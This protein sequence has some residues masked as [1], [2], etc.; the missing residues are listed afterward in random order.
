MSSNGHEV[1]SIYQATPLQN[2]FYFDELY[3]RA[4]K[5]HNQQTIEIKGSFDLP[6]FEQSLA[7]IGRRHETLRANFRYLADGGLMQIIERE[8][9]PEVRC[10]NSDEARVPEL[11]EEEYRREFKLAEGCLWRTLVVNLGSTRHVIVITCHHIIIDGWSLAMVMGELLDVYRHLSQGKTPVLKQPWPL[12]NYFRWLRQRSSETAKTFWRKY[13]AG[14]QPPAISFCRPNPSPGQY[15]PGEQLITLDPKTISRLRALASANHFTDSTFFQVAWAAVLQCYTSSNDTV[16]GVVVSGRSPDCAGIEDAVG[17]FINTVPARIQVDANSKILATLIQR[18]ADALEVEETGILTLAEVQTYAEQKGALIDHLVVFENFPASLRQ[19]EFSTSEVQLRLVRVREQTSYDFN[20]IITP[21]EEL[22]VAFK[23]NRQTMPDGYVTRLAGHYERVVKTMLD[24]PRD[25]FGDLDLLSPEERRELLERFND[26]VRSQPERCVHEMVEEQAAA[27]PDAVAIVLENRELSYADLNARA[28]QLAHR[29][30][31]LGVGPEEPVAILADRSFE[32]VVAILATLKAGGAYVPIAPNNPA[33]R[34]EQILRLSGCRMLL[35]FGENDTSKLP[36]NETVLELS[37]PTWESA[38]RCNPPPRAQLQNLAYVIFTS[39]STGQP[40]GCMVTHQALASHL[41]WM[42]KNYRL[43]PDDVV[44]QKTTYTFDV[45]IWELLLPLIVGGKTA[46]LRPGAEKDPSAILQALEEHQTTV[47][48]FVPSMLGAFLDELPPEKSLPAW[49]QCWC[50][51]EPLTRAH[52]SLFH[53]KTGGA[54]E[55]HNLYGPTEATIIVASHRVSPEEAVIPIGRTFANTTLYVL[56]NWSRPVPPGVIGELYIGGTQVA[57]GYS[58]RPDLTADRFGADPFS[59]GGRLYRTGD[60][61]RWS[62]QGS[63]ELLGRTDDQ[64]KIRGYRIELAEIAG[65]LETHPAVKTA[66]VVARGDGDLRHL[67][68][69]FVPRGELSAEQARAYLLTQLP[70]YMVPARCVALAEIPLTASG[71]IDRNALP[72]P[73]IAVGY[74]SAPT[75]NTESALAKLFAE[76]LSVERVGI[77]HNF[78]D[79]GGHS[80]LAIRLAARIQKAFDVE[81][82][83]RDLFA[84]PSIDTLAEVIERKRRVKLAPIFPVGEADYYPSSSA[85]KRMYAL[86]HAFGGVAYNLPTVYRVRGSLDVAQLRAALSAVVCRHDA[87]RTSFHLVDG[88]I[89]QKVGREANLAL[90]VVETVSE[91]EASRLARDFIQPFD[92]GCAPLVRTKVIK[93]GVAEH[94]LCIDMHH[95]V[96]D[97]AS[98][99]LLIRDLAAAYQGKVLPT[100]ALQYKD[101]VAWKQGEASEQRDL[102]RTYWTEQFRGEIPMLELPTDFVRPVTQSFEGLRVRRSLA[103]S[104]SA[105]LR[106]FCRNRGLTEYMALFAAYM[107]VLG[108]LSRQETVVVGAPVAGRDHPDLEEVVGMFVNTVALS[109]APAGGKRCSD[110]LDEVRSKVLGALAHQSYPL[111]E[112]IASLGLD[113]DGSRN[114]LFNTMFVFAHGAGQSPQESAL[115]LEQVEFDPG[116]SRFD[117]TLIAQSAEDIHF[118][119]EFCPQLFK[120]ETILRWG[121]MLEQVIEQLID[122]PQRRLC[123]LQIL[124]DSEL[125]QLHGAFQGKPAVFRLDRD[126]H[127]L[128]EMQAEMAPNAIAIR[129]GTREESYRQVDE[130][131]NRLAHRLAREGIG[132]NSLVALPTSDPLETVVGILAILKAGGAYVPLDIE[133]PA[134]RIQQILSDSNCAAQLLPHGLSEWPDSGKRAV[135]MDDEAVA[136]ESSA[137]IGT[138]SSLRDLAYVIYTSGSTGKPKGVMVERGALVNSTQA[139]LA[140]YAEGDDSSGRRYLLLSSFSFD[141]SVAS[142]FAALTSGAT[143]VV[144]G[145]RYKDP[146]YVAEVIERERITDLLCIPR[147][148]EAIL[149]SKGRATFGSLRRVIVAGE[150]CPLALVRQHQEHVSCKFFNEYGPTE[151]T[152]WTTVQLCDEQTGPTIPIGKPIFNSRVYIVDSSTSSV[153]LGL[154]GEICI[155]GFGI[156]R[157][158]WGLPDLTAERFVADPQGDGDRLYRT[159]DL[160]RWRPDGSID[161][162]G[163]LDQQ[164]KLQGF[165]VE[166]GEIE[167][168]LRA[169]PAITSAVVT[170]KQDSLAKSLCAY[171]SADQEFEPNQLRE[172]AQQRLPHYM[173]PRFFVRVRQWPFTPN[174]KID[175]RALP[176]PAKLETY[177]GPGDEI[178]SRLVEVIARTLRLDRIGV[179]DNYFAAGGDSIKAIQVVSRMRDYGYSVSVKDLFRYPTVRQL[180]G[181]VTAATNEIPQGEVLGPVRFGPIQRWFIELNLA[182]PEHYNQAII[183]RNRRWDAVVLRRVLHRLAVHHDA[184]GSV[185]N[186]DCTGMDIL[187]AERRTVDV[188]EFLSGGQTESARFERAIN[189]LHASFDLQKGPLLKAMVFGG[190]SGG[191]L[192]LV[193]H[194][195]IVDGVS[196]RILVE[197]LE[198]LYEQATR[199]APLTLPPKT[200]SYQDWSRKL[201]EY[202]QSAALRAELEFWRPICSLPSTIVPSLE[203]NSERAPDFRKVTIVIARS[204]GQLLLREVHKAYTT[205]TNDVLL[206]AL[207]LA[208]SDWLGSGPFRVHLEGHGREDI[209]PGLNVTRTVG[210]F[211]SLFPIALVGA[212]A[213]PGAYLRQTKEML[214]RIP[215]RGIGYGILRYLTEGEGRHALRAPGEFVFNYLGDIGEAPPTLPRAVVADCP[216]SPE[217]RRPFAINMD[218]LMQ[219]EE[220]IFHLNYDSTRLAGKQI[221]RFAAAYRKRL[222]E[223]IEHCAAQTVRVY[224]A[225]DLGDPTLNEQDLNELISG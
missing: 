115:A 165:R 66:T 161:F 100:A 164:I 107:I 86:Q 198:T 218:G 52:V 202:A 59:T 217:N 176:E 137:R 149:S 18:Q 45:S 101:Y 50:A 57:R 26:T 92:L 51:G 31:E 150:E 13:L 56:D 183:R 146:E 140:H 32:L 159:G 123:E 110:Y 2:G 62:P 41:W 67:V 40:K 108:R 219:S 103:P 105:R 37:R 71:K 135:Y 189:D 42:A 117:L 61:A 191:G 147:Y 94:F 156:A 162:L 119:W 93:W 133:Y 136:A 209:V 34:I 6:A 43:G 116:V 143:L 193:A 121:G 181:R 199:Q 82:G 78:F 222:E 215:N 208:L 54:V 17:L 220:I 224:T 152:V 169:H 68:A 96:S 60:L 190:E 124:T 35:K 142:I 83:V 65:V 204:Y 36:C 201:H 225:S 141:S 73:E 194:H 114:P 206:A 28:N 178:E 25:R 118:S 72:V 10:C 48:T 102:E 3:A 187:P 212:K 49:R 120:R 55:L 39:G 38:P 112:L 75:T 167:A 21:G 221:E 9:K 20:V 85:Q 138:R 91:H 177:E 76:V 223:L 175:L 69:Y 214:R 155:G 24:R 211:T 173:V 1:E 99:T 192:L 15:V 29:L 87:L 11:A 128:F 172:H 5:A 179:T 64:L 134:E 106:A 197:D 207:G 53:T 157:G 80:L 151:G 158:Y 98:A 216:I 84:H 90:D 196:W 182:R 170:V 33:E 129:Y 88:E 47:V 210:W 7:T 97:L 174:G 186:S 160:A 8:K 153:P 111:E 109:T 130:R 171:Y 4:R 27:T 163:R 195:L 139:R 44:L 213:G 185:L 30:I 205:E 113:R 23:Y 63:L 74:Y 70:D 180:A 166:P 95:I 19:T 58:R 127:E 184:L 16:F 125:R 81:L 154:P 104:T 148:Y 12:K 46:L 131:A 89:V 22:T 77:G 188:L 122:G 203:E 200:H 14:Y 168:V 144:L 145:P 132:P 126:I 79:L